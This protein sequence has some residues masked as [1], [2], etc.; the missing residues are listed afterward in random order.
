MKY[1]L[2]IFIV[3]F[4]SSCS[5]KKTDY[6]GEY[7]R[8]VKGGKYA[9]FNNKGE[10]LT[11]GVYENSTYPSEGYIA[12]VK[13]G[14]WGYLDRAGNEVIP[15]RYKRASPFHNGL[16]IVYVS[17][18]KMGFIDK[19]ATFV[20]PPKFE[21]ARHFSEGIA[22]VEKDG[23]WGYIDRNG[24]PITSFRYDMVSNFKNGRAKAYIQ[25]ANNTLICDIYKNGIEKCY[26][27]N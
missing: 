5:V 24:K 14:E 3:L 4:V 25:E 21:F 6:S 26:L 18:N 23:K 11:K 15:F 20:I 13:N 12:T 19:N 16:A 2:M 8:I 17:E 1:F 27:K 7:F 9:L 22:A 10:Q